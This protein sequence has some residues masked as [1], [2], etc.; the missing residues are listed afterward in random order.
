MGDYT[1]ENKHAKSP[2]SMPNRQKACESKE[3]DANGWRV[4]RQ[5][6]KERFKSAKL[7]EKSMEFQP[8]D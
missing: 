5:A 3:K 7:P 2:K 1:T 4:S 6:G 8:T